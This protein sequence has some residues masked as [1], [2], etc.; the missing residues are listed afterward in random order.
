MGMIPANLRPD[1][2]TMRADLAAEVL[3]NI[4]KDGWTLL[5]MA[6][7]VADA[8]SDQTGIAALGGATAAVNYLHNPGSG[9]YVQAASPA[10][11]ARHFEVGGAK[12]QGFVVITA[13]Q[14]TKVR[15]GFYTAPAAGITWD[16]RIETDA[17]GAP[18]GVLA[19]PN[20]IK[21]GCT[22]ANPGAANVQQEFALNGAWTPTIA[23]VYWLVIRNVSAQAINVW[24]Y[25]ASDTYP[26]G[27]A[28]SSDAALTG[29]F[30]FG[31][32][33]VATPANVAVVSTAFAPDAAVSQLRV[34]ALWQPVDSATM[35]VDCLI[36]L[37]ADGGVTWVP[38]ALD[39]LGKY[40]AATRVIGGTV[41]AAGSSIKWRWRTANA[42]TQRLRG[43]WLQW[44]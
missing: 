21:A 42:K 40:D 28:Y 26:N 22:A 29:D 2:D 44:R 20:A 7:G 3:R 33:Q 41:A 34:V 11:D 14:I 27:A 32:Y 8:F 25:T 30:Y 35:D 39:D 12:A 43:V 31:V 17:A 23:T 4:V 1:L 13:D 16:I 10:G 37:S 5:D 15:L 18:S 6:A 24:A 9:A 38:V 19:H 36:D